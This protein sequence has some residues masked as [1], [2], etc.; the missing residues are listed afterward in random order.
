MRANTIRPGQKIS[1]NAV[2]QGR[3]S[4]EFEIKLPIKQMQE[5]KGDSEN[6][7]FSSEPLNSRSDNS[8]SECKF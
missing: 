7:E 4:S 6:S 2:T 8:Y 3:I 5:D 1:Q